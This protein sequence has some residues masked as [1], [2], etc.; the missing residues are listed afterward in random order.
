M[1]LGITGHLVGVFRVRVPG[2][3]TDLSNSVTV[4]DTVRNPSAAG[5]S[6]KYQAEEPSSHRPGQRL[7]CE[8]WKGLLSPAKTTLLAESTVISNSS[9]EIRAS[10]SVP[11]IVHDITLQ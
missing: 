3:D 2:L 1:R 6:G 10:Q 4:E 8:R 11:P 7:N 9:E 5:W